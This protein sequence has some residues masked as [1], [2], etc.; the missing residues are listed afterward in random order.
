MVHGISAGATSFDICAIYHF[1]FVF[2][3]SRSQLRFQI[4]ESNK[5]SPKQRFC[6]GS[7]EFINTDPRFPHNPHHTELSPVSENYSS[8]ERLKLNF[9]DVGIFE[10][11]SEDEIHAQNQDNIELNGALANQT[12]GEECEFSGQDS[13]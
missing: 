8:P 12:P 2:D 3:C 1:Y 9:Q 13:V 4:L 7:C 5:Y 11:D 6:M 10:S